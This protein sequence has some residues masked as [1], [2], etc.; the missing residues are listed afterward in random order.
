M[1]TLS[2]IT[3]TEPGKWFERFRERTS[4]GG[5]AVAESANPLEA[6]AAGETELALTRL[7]DP[8]VDTGIHHVVELYREEPGVALS[9][10]NELTLLDGTIGPE[11]V[12]GEI[13]N[14]RIDD[15]GV[16]DVSKVRESLQVVAANVG[17]VIAPRPL[18]RV[19]SGKQVEH[20]GYRDSSVPD[21]RIALVWRKTADSDAI[22][23]FVGIARG[24]TV[25]S[26]RQAAPRRSAREKSLAKQARRSARK[27]ETKPP[28]KRRR[29]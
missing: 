6:L 24:R 18:L 15:S 11:D 23:D 17:I 8:R 10:D 28:R 3:G 1:L 5:L 27:P 14:Y 20:R 7:P 2:F 26:T 29:K 22:Q 21:T 9:K 19:L 12:A 4:H 16:V 25:N 13:C